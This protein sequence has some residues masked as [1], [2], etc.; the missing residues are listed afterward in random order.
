M[1]DD[2][3]SPGDAPRERRPLDRR[4]LKVLVFVPLVA[5]VGVVV[6]LLGVPWPLV[7]AALVLFVLWLVFEG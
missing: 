2:P 7:V 6:L 5:V 1:S 3:L 4:H